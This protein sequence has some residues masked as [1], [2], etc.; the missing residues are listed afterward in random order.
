MTV[1]K[2]RGPY[3]RLPR[4]KT[5]TKRVWTEFWDDR[6]LTI[7][8]G[9]TFFV[10]LALFPGIASVVS[11]YG[12]FADRGTLAQTIDIL[13]GFLPGGAI[14]VLREDLLRLIAL[15][16][17]SLDFTFFGGLLVA[18]WSASGGFKTLVDALNVAYEVPER[19]SFITL[20]INALIFTVATILAIVVAINFVVILP[21][22]A[23]AAIRNPVLEMAAKLA[24][25][26]LALV[27]SAFTLA[28]I[29][30]YG[31]AKPRPR[32]RW[33]TWGSLI[34]SF[35]WLVGTALF[36]WYA[37]N[38]GGYDQTYGALGALVGFLTWIWLSVVLILLGAE[39]NCELDRHE[40]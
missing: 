9:V 22:L 40:G 5:I 36:G 19:R 6:V 28:L 18:V 10:M 33:I 23:E 37:S 4:I 17:S 3:A 24:L 20:S 16:Q 12:M 11:L 26:P 29:Y 39:I 31:P 35:L 38:F 27:V 30:R 1:R 15:D 8:G 2:R 34:T 13:D 32:W 14:A 21:T 7:A 25:W